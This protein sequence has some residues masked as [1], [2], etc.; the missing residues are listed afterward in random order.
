MALGLASTGQGFLNG[1]A[2]AYAA[3][4]WAFD[5][6]QRTTHLAYLLMASWLGVV[7]G[8]WLPWALDLVSLGAAVCCVVQVTRLARDP[9]V[10][11]AGAVACVMPWCAFA[12]VDLIWSALLLCA[13]A[14]NTARQA[15]WW[16]ALAVGTSPVALLLVPWMC[17]RRGP[18]G[19]ATGALAAVCAL[20]VV[21]WGA[22]WWGDRGVVPG[23]IVEPGRLAEAAIIGLPWALCVLWRPRAQVLWLLPV[24]LAPPDIPVWIWLGFVW[25]MDVGGDAWGRRLALA[26]VFLASFGLQERVARVQREQAVLQE[27]VDSMGPQ[28]GLVAPWSWGVRASVMATGEAYGLR[29]R[30]PG[31]SLLGSQ[32]ARWCEARPSRV[33]SLPPRARW[34][35]GGVVDDVG[36]H[37]SIEPPMEGCPR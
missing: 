3:Q 33:A 36:V 1:D 34:A 2:A 31:P 7:A 30:I 32:E 35:Q 19:V 21:T 9:G 27:V 6:A 12:E 14:A 11:C 15:A 26:S 25:A 29:W 10:G 18:R 4:G 24:V 20:T 22:W 37:W 28:D 13:L 23:L 16:T 8:P 17:A 5:L